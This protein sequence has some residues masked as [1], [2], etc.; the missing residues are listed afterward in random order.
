MFPKDIKSTPIATIKEFKKHG[1]TYR[2]LDYNTA[3][4]LYLFGV[5]QTDGT[6]IAWEVIKPRKIRGVETYPSDE[7]FGAYAK[8]ISYSKTLEPKMRQYFT[9]GW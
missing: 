8:C 3:T 1:H 4:N 5:Y 6:Q 7:N 2:F 9:Q